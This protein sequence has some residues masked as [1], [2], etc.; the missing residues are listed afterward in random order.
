MAPKDAFKL[1]INHENDKKLIQRIRDNIQQ[2]FTNK[3]TINIYEVGQKALLHNVI[4]IKGEFLLTTR[5]KKKLGFKKGFYIPVTIMK[6]YQS[7]IKVQINKNSLIVNS[8]LLKN[9]TFKVGLDLVKAI[10]DNE[11]MTLV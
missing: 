9:S 1:N 8:E 4:T 7:N 11:W 5:T 6:V 3:I 10:S 2:A